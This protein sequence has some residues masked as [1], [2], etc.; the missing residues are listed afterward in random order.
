MKTIIEKATLKKAL[1]FTAVFAA[2]YI[3][4]N[5]TTLG[6]AGLLRITNGANIL[7]FQFGYSAAKAYDILT[8]LGQEGRSYY[9]FHILPLDFPF[10][11]SGMLFYAGWIALLVKLVAPS[12]AAGFTILVPLLSMMF[13]WF[14]NIGAIIM[15][16][17]YPNLSVPGVY[18]GSVSG[19]LKMIFSLGNI[20]IIV[21]LVVTY[22]FKTVK[23][24]HKVER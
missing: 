8:A 3:I 5:F 18:L 21:V 1:L 20:A 11:L 4:I 19:M 16:N 24:K 14:E 6:L 9:L 15:L 10:P 22:L 7:D 12:S 2:L 17:T 23:N 13:D